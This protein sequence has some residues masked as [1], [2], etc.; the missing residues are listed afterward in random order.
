M[1]YFSPSSVMHLTRVCPVHSSYEDL[2]RAASL[3][4]QALDAGL[5]FKIPFYVTPGY[6]AG[7]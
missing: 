4:R 5:K 3:V 6:V 2:S 7:E 1:P